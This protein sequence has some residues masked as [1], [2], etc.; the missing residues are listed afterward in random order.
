MTRLAH[1]QRFSIWYDYAFIGLFLLANALV[2]AG[3]RISD[4]LRTSS[5]L[6][7]YR[8][9]PYVWEL[10]SAFMIL[11]LVPFLRQLLNS[12]LS[13]WANLNATLAIYLLASVVFSALHVTGMVVIRK[14]VYSYQNMDY[15]FGYIVSEFLYEYQ[16]DLITFVLIV[17]L[18]AM[19]RSLMERIQGQA[20]MLPAGE[21]DDQLGNHLLVRKI[22]KEF[23]VKIQDID[24]LESSGNY[25]N[26]H[27]GERVYPI[28]YTLNKLI[29]K[30]E[31]K[32][33]CRTHR[34][35]GVNLDAIQS[36]TPNPTGNS[37][38]TLK[39][40]TTLSLSRR[41]REELKRQFGQH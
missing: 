37:E 31:P 21:D 7:F 15:E 19:H 39:N 35:S 28:R 20:N 41:Y 9:E 32:G 10:S 36:I 11:A 5:E 17:A 27:V 33:F 38:L 34:S 40:G 1:Y 23:V 8:W 16:K 24:W 12:K 4:S 26:L 3:S 6:P 29:D 2:L 13:N 14:I 30:L 25:V 22:G 18:F